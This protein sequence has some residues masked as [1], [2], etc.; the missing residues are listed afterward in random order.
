[1]NAHKLKTWPQPFE[2]V[3]SGE[4]TFEWR[5][6]DRG[7]EQNDLVMLEEWDPELGY[8]GRR[9]TGSIGYVL[10]APAFGVPEGFCVF[11]VIELDDVETVSPVKCVLC[12]R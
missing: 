5:K 7:V 4:K 3:L 11:S 10:R 12:S 1:M 2:A 8:T 6:D 9:V